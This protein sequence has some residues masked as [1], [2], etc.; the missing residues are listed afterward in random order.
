MSAG[1][2]NLKNK[3][4]YLIGLIKSQKKKS[5]ISSDDMMGNN[6]AGDQVLLDI[7]QLN[8]TYGKH[9]NMQWGLGLNVNETEIKVRMAC[10]T[11][12]CWFFSTDTKYFQKSIVVVVGI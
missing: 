8:I 10:S 11:S 12:S 1:V 3:A 9:Y 2:A 6:G 5:G 7:S 4:A